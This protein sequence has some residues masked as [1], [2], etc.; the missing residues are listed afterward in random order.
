MMN[1]KE[2]IESIR[3]L[4]PEV[5]FLGQK[6]KSIAN[7]LMFQPHIHTAAMTYELAHDPEYQEIMTATSH[8]SGKRINRFTHIHHS[9][10]D[11]VKR[12]RM[13]RLLGQKI[14]TCFQRCA[15]LDGLNT[16]YVTTYDI[17]QKQGTNYHERFK[18]YLLEV[19]ENDWM[20][21]GAMTDARG[22]RS[23]RP[24]KQKHPDTYLHIKER[25]EDGIIVS[26]MKAE[27]LE[28]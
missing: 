14:G 23:L 10:A 20:P 11:L 13:M 26:G 2:Y 4:N 27:N 17:D 21:S 9:I 24:S 19:Q 6:I 5:Y 18:K 3:G 8:L 22:D 1:G 28:D 7:E 16:V 12:V 25:L 15:G